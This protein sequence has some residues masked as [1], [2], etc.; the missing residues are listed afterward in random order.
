MFKKINYK[1]HKWTKTLRIFTKPCVYYECCMV[2]QCSGTGCG[3]SHPKYSPN[4]C[5][6]IYFYENQSRVS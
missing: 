3:S 1:C 2:D 5:V 4:I 6:N